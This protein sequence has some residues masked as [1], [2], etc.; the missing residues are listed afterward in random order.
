ML[1]THQTADYTFVIAAHKNLVFQKPQLII[2]TSSSQA[3]LWKY[4]L[5]LMKVHD[6]LF[7][8]FSVCELKNL[9]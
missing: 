2:L 6:L 9:V 8:Q 7:D 3:Y 4:S 1:W 5:M